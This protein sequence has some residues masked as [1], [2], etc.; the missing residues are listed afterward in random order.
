MNNKKATSKLTTRFILNPTVPLL[1]LLLLF[2]A[3]L[4]GQ[5]PTPT[6]IQDVEDYTWWYVTLFILILGFVAAVGWWFSSK[7][8]ESP[9][10]G[11]SG[12]SGGVNSGGGGAANGRGRD[13]FAGSDYAEVN[14]VDAEKELEWLRKN[15][16]I[17]NRRG[18]KKA[19][20]QKF[21]AGLPRPSKVFEG[22]GNGA[23]A[24]GIQEAAGVSKA[25]PPL[26]V[27][28]FS[29][30][31]LARPFNLLPLSNDEA[32]LSAIEQTQEEFEE[33]EEVR[34]LSVRILAAFKTR[35]SVEALSQV[36]LYDLSS[37]LRS[38]AVSILADFDHESVFETILL[39]CADPT[40]EVRAAAARGFTRLTFDRADAWTRIAETGETGRM[41]HAAR[42][43]I[44]GGFVDR[45]FDRLIHP[46]SKQAYEAVTLLS[47]LVLS[48]ETGPIFQRLRNDRNVELW[49]A[50]LHVIKITDSQNILND[51]YALLEQ[52][53]LSS[54][55]KKAIDETIESVGLVAA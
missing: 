38:K 33:D 2:S 16:G 23:E 31:E 26:P 7:Q 44:E 40:R 50:V 14:A 54:D 41:R 25:P 15:N 34:E 51:L 52:K 28:G 48:G 55:L 18:K 30:L 53:S 9:F 46:D 39:A 32:L 11:S 27:Y 13:N 42:A 49:R 45:V 19:A 36:A 22:N 37:T 43:A 29:K 6:P 10:G 24:A 5:M 17:I 47:L 3:R 4:Y 12:N 8:S 21:P 35:N 1:L 20:K